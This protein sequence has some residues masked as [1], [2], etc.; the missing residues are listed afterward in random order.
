MKMSV[1]FVVM[2]LFVLCSASIRA[3]IP[4]LIN[5]QGMLT[6]N[7]GKPLNGTF[8]IVFG[9]YDSSSGG[10]IKWEEI[11][12]TVSVTQGLFNVILGSIN[13]NGVNLD[14]S[15]E[16]WLQITVEG[17]DMPERLR[18][19]SVGYAYRAL[20]ADSARVA[21][22]GSGSH[23]SVSDSVLYTNKYWGIARGG[24]GN[25]LYGDSTHTHVN[26]GVACTT[27][28][29]GQSYTFCTVGG[30]VGNKAG[31][32]VAT[33]GGGFHNN[34]S[35][36]GATVGGGRRN[37]ASELGPTVG[38]GWD[39]T[40]SDD[41][42]TVG[43]GKDN[44]ASYDYATVG[45][46]QDNTASNFHATVGGGYSNTASG[47]S[48]TVG[49]GCYD[50]ASGVCATVPGGDL[51]TASGHYSFAAGYRAKA[52]HIGSFVWADTTGAD[53]SSTGASQ[54]L[55]RA[56]GGVGIGTPSP[57]SPLHVL[58]N[59]ASGNAS[60]ILENLHPTGHARISFRPNSTEQGYIYANVNGA[61]VYNT[62]GGGMYFRSNGADKML[63]KDNGN[64]GIGTT[65]PGGFKL[66][67]N[68]SA[69]KVGGGSWDVFSDLRLKEIKAPYEYGLPEISKLNPVHYS[70]KEDNVLGLPGGKEFV[71]LV[72][73]EVKD[74]IPDA[75]KEND[76][77]YLMLNNDPIIWAMLNA[78]KELNAENEELKKRIEALENK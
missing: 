2:C 61:T 11:H 71:G 70:Y 52:L 25:I 72:A 8:M 51:N 23:W 48:A 46:G 27:A 10:Q 18:F 37:T 35:G 30:G 14:F 13:P 44:T 54:F 39:N 76:K 6:D 75:V 47:N 20:V 28:T 66:A 77:G 12:P 4:K 21:T 16:Y 69:A 78:I 5:Y 62:N 53:F 63:I 43:G 34:A 32:E 64:V 57:E 7:D 17:E 59:D 19:T 50:T 38:G 40:A 33:V 74:V 42:A 55:I 36:L 41:F 29:I 56:S 31:E 73:Q 24:A 58:H 15:E 45:G 65:D 49:G 9:I 1:F 60:L 3:D 26:L 68:G 22:P 67:V